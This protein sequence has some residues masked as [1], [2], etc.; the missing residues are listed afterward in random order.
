MQAYIVKHQNPEVRQRSRS[1]GAFVALTD[2]LLA[3]GWRV[4]GCALTEDF[5]AAH[6]LAADAAER[7][8]FC[9]SKYVQS[10]PGDSYAQVAQAL[11]TGGVCYSGTPCQVAGLQAFLQAAGADTTRL[12]TV[13]IAC[14]GVPSPG[15][16]QAYLRALAQRFGGAVEAV[17]FRDKAF[18][19]TATRETVRIAGQTHASEQFSHLFYGHHCLRPA[20]AHCRY[21]RLP[22]PGDL[23][24]ADAWG[25]SR[26]HADFAD[27]LGV[28]LVLVHTDRGQ[29]AFEQAKA[30]LAWRPV[31]FA[32]FA[33]PALRRNHPPTPRRSRFWRR[34]RRQGMP[35]VLRAY[36]KRSWPRRLKQWALRLLRRNHPQGGNRV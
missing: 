3:A 29:A 30:A 14:H 4:A 10:A 27:A 9:G 26:H 19:W 13:D 5:S 35:A 28:S 36:G 34:L 22:R 11:A 15:V 23:T 6:A 8:A 33:Q 16:W 24:L 32:D 7:D 2:P 17:N 21:K 18:G 31:A 1:G 12:L 20:C 25:V